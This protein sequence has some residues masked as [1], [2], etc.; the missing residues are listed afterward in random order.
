L[1]NGK[2][3]IGKASFAKN[4]AFEIL[5]AKNENHPDILIIE[6]EDGKKEISV[7][8][9]REISSFLNQTSAISKNKVIIIDSADELNRSSSNALLKI[10][11]E[12]RNNN[13]LILISHSISKLLP[14]I[15]S[16][17]QIIKINDLSFD[18]FS[19]I[20]KSEMPQILD[21]QIK[22]LSE[23]CDNSPAKAINDGE[24]LIWL[25]DSFLNSLKDKKI[26]EE[27]LKK[28]ADK[29]FNF[30]NFIEII[31]FF[32]LRLIKFYNGKTDYFLFDEKEVFQDLKNKFSLEQI[33]Y[34]NDE[35]NSSI[36]RANSL[37]LDKK[38]TFINF[39]NLF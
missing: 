5:D 11:E 16:R 10:L 2:S 22:I 35:A 31:N 30:E 12:P 26:D 7:E 1:L 38:L 4:F 34:I 19:K 3:G 13:F 33:F 8:K 21:E 20:V 29:K 14:T 15:R 24:D 36:A 37:S 17:C 25:Y 32:F 28:L 6:K 39:Y 18:D 23:I 27:L 9:I